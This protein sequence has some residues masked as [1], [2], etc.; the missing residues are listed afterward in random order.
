V[1]PSTRQLPSAQESDQVLEPPPT[2]IRG[3]A[4]AAGDVVVVV[5]V[6]A[7]VVAVVD[8]GAAVSDTFCCVVAVWSGCGTAVL[9]IAPSSMSQAAN[10]MTTA[11]T[12][13][14]RLRVYT[15]IPLG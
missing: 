12:T 11:I 7:V 6:G 13:A 9:S 1:F 5:V 14:N 8:D 3:K 15:T 2:Y 10:N 4:R